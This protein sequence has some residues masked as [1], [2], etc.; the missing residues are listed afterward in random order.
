MHTTKDR[1]TEKHPDP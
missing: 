1:V